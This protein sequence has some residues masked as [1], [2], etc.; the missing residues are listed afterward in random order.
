MRCA[1]CFKEIGS[2]TMCPLCGFDL[3]AEQQRRYASKALPLMHRLA[4]KY[5]LGEMLGAGGFGITYLARDTA[6]GKLVAVKEFFPSELCD[7]AA[8]GRVIPRR[9]EETFTKSVQHFYEEAKTLYALGRCPSVAGVDGFFRGNNT[10]YIVMEYARGETL[11]AYTARCGNRVPYNYAKHIVIQIALALSEVHALGIVHSDISPSN[12]LIQPSGDVKLVDF[13]ASRSFLNK[14]NPMQTVQ[15]K[16]GF[17]PPEQ[18]TGSNL[19]LGPWTDIYALACTFYRIATGKMPPP[20]AERR[21]GAAVTPMSVYVPETEPRVEDTIN[22]AMELDFQKRYKNA[23][24]FIADFTDYVRQEN[25]T[26]LQDTDGGTKSVELKGKLFEKLRRAVKSKLNRGSE[27]KTP[28]TEAYV[29]VIEGLNPGTKIRL[30]PGRQYLIGRQ[31]D[32]C[33]MVVSNSSVISRV[34]CAMSFNS[35]ERTVMLYDKSSNGITLG[36]GRTLR[37]ESIS[38][39]GDSMV[40]LSEGEVILNIVIKNGQGENG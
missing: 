24:E 22:H 5:E 32:I 26:D 11:K 21:A 34:H 8:D 14:S 4:G 9:S 2:E 3:D 23:D 1:R 12:I 18:Y 31:A 25:V 35:D 6:D 38:L 13:G 39:S 15:V 36:N 7:R 20:A 30:E 28:T 40:A 37:G 10:S 33:D 19:K 16:P 29:E 17:A 27:Q